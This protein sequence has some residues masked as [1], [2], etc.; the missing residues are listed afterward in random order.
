MPRKPRRYGAPRRPLHK[1]R[2][3]SQ[4][5]KNTVT[6]CTRNLL[7]KYKENCC[8]RKNVGKKDK[9]N[10]FSKNLCSRDMLTITF[11]CNR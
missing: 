3:S 8:C 11:V 1:P 4:S 7:T 9:K 6:Q 10:N 5:C 2:S